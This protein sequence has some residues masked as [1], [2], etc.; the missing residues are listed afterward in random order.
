MIILCSVCNLHL[1]TKPGQGVTHG[2]CRFHLL[3]TLIKSKLATDEESAEFKAAQ[4]A[5]CRKPRE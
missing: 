4:E 3:E 2:Y 5:R 1:G